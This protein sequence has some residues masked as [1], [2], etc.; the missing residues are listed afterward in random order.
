MFI[1]VSKWVNTLP[2]LPY[3]LD[4]SKWQELGLLILLEEGK[5]LIACTGILVMG[6]V[7]YSM[8]RSGST[9]VF[10]ET[11]ACLVVESAVLVKPQTFQSPSLPQAPFAKTRE[12]RR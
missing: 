7:M 8:R 5:Q 12:L 6:M 4:K 3:L 1:A 2:P 9:E 11:E 10:Q